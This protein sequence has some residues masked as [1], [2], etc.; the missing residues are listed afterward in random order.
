MECEVAVMPDVLSLVSVIIECFHIYHHMAL[1][2][3]VSIHMPKNTNKHMQS[4]NA[5]PLSS[6]H[7]C[8]CVCVWERERASECVCVWEREKKRERERKRE[9]VCVRFFAKPFCG[10]SFQ[11]LTSGGKKADIFRVPSVGA[12]V[13]TP[14]ASEVYWR[15]ILNYSPAPFT[16]QHVCL[17]PHT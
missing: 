13:Q 8:V 6:S 11:T 1:E 3:S 10:R 9:R 7:A 5:H 17:S 12:P 14:R 4:Q 15:S 2:Q 16:W